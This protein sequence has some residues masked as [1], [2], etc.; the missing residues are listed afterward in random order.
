M[1]KQTR[2]SLILSRLDL[3][4]PR[5]M[6]NFLITAIRITCDSVSGKKDDLSDLKPKIP[7]NKNAMIT[8]LT[9]T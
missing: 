6:Q 8:T 3:R 1:C 4:E 2:L 9:A 7:N 5:A